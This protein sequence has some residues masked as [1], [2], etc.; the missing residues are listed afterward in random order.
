MKDV[1]KEE[2]EQFLKEHTSA[3]PDG[4]RVV[5]SYVQTRYYENGIEVA[6]MSS[7]SFGEIYE[8]TP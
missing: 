7:D 8:T 5:G 6:R 1:T 3:I 4:F 2:F